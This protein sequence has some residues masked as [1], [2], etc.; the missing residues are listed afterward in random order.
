MSEL[1]KAVVQL[2]ANPEQWAAFTAV[3][4]TVV[5]APRSG[6]TQ[7]LTARAATDLRDN[8]VGPRGAACITMTNEAGSR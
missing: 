5:L 3:G 2:R 7:L 1:A 6:K 4:D 8:S